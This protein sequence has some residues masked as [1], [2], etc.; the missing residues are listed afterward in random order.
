[1]LDIK[2]KKLTETAKI[3]TKGH[4]ADAGYDLYVDNF[5]KVSRTAM[6][7]SITIKNNKI[8]SEIDEAE[9]IDMFKVHTGIAINV[10]LGYFG[11]IAPRSSNPKN[12]IMIHDGVID[13]GYTGELI[14]L[15]WGRSSGVKSEI[16]PLR[17]GDRI[18]QLIIQKHEDA[19]WHVTDDLGESERG[20]AGFGSTGE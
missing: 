8:T 12:N 17:H 15:A 3:P 4:P 5:E 7:S 14:V 18:A 9:V 1:M 10:P 2:V 11:R 13:S 20:S 16:L 6:T 19:N